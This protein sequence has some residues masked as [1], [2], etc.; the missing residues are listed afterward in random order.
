MTSAERGGVE[1]WKGDGVDANSTG[2]KWHTGGAR[3]ALGN[4]EGMEL[5]LAGSRRVA[6]RTRASRHARDPGRNQRPATP[7]DPDLTSLK[8]QGSLSLSSVSKLAG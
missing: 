5:G 4:L 6:D 2:V 7:S 3:L 8:T 1:A